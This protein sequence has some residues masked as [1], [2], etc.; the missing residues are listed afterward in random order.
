MLEFDDVY[1]TDHTTNGPKYT[2]AGEDEDNEYFEYQKSI[3][4]YN[5][6]NAKQTTFGA[7]RS[8]YERGSLMQ[9]IMDP[10]ADSARDEHGSILHTVTQK[11]IDDLMGDDARL[12]AQYNK[13]KTMSDVWDV[14]EE[15]EESF[16]LALLEE[17]ESNN[18]EFSVDEFHK[19]LDKELGVFVQGEKYSYTKDLKD[20]YRNS[21]K[22]STEQ[23]IFATIPDHV[24]WDIKTP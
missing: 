21:L 9:K 17:L 6:S 4:E 8:V 18:S 11:E 19:V 23:K 10:F 14:D 22:T 20:A 7:K 16:R 3:D 1:V 5:N 2:T 15:E 13:L 12:R 24:F